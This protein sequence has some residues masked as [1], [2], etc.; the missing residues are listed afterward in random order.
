MISK[1]GSIAQFQGM[2]LAPSVQKQKEVKSWQ[3]KIAAIPAVVA[4]FKREKGLPAVARDTAATTALT[5]QAP[6][7]V[8]IVAAVMRSAGNKFHK[9]AQG[10]RPKAPCALK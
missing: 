3:I 10:A 1:A 8:E 2:R 5:L 9:R 4:K 6:A 7:A